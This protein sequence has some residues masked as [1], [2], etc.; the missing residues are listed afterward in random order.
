MSDDVLNSDAGKVIKSKV[1]SY[2][3]RREYTR[4]ELQDKCRTR[5]NA[6]VLEIV[7]DYFSAEGYQSDERFCESFVRA[8][9]AQG[10]G[11]EKIRQDLRA[12]GIS[13]MLIE[14]YIEEAN[15]TVDED[16]TRVYTNKYRGVPAKDQKEK[17][18]RL[19]F[20]VSR[21]FSPS[22]IYTLLNN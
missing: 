4:R 22:K 15:T 20:L 7:L 16:L 3:S 2:L 6:D 11:P 19:R 8:R 12:R 14:Q 5:D 21:G 18:R 1:F 17:A 10:K 13:S 9:K